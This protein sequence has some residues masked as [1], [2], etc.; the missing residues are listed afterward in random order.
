MGTMKFEVPHS[1]PKDEV[2]QR[3]EQLLKY[4]QEK[5]GVKAD[6]VGDGAK[7]VGKVMGINLDASFTITDKGVEGEGTDPGMLLRGQA[8]KYLQQKF[9][10]A[11]DPTK[12]PDDVGKGLA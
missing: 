8:K 5:Y 12:S 3:V 6:W 9:T 10:A 7:V 11:L 4:W 1:L 2:R